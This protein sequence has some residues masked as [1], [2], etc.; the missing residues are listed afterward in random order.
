MADT[1]ETQEEKQEVEFVTPD[2]AE[3]LLRPEVEKLIEEGWRIVS[4]PLYGVRLEKE[5]EILDLRVDLTGNIERETKLSL[6]TGA[7]TGRLIAW[8]LLMASILVTLA[9]ASALGILD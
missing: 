7:D 1:I 3:D 9:L 2:Q 6:F 8:V 4:K 5:R